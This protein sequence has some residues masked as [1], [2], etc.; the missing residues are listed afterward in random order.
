MNFSMISGKK[1]IKFNS[2]ST[3]I[4]VGDKFN[5]NPLLNLSLNSFN[6]IG[7]YKNLRLMWSRK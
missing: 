1:V 7:S 6:H 5:I 3:T 2:R 4:A